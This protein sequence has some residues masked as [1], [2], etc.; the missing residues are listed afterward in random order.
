MNDD[1]HLLHTYAQ[2]RPYALVSLTRDEAEGTVSADTV[3]EVRDLRVALLI[4]LRQ[5][6]HVTRA[7]RREV[8]VERAARRRDQQRTGSA[9]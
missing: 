1:Q 2:H 8:R 6:F 4:A 7:I 5:T 3:R 9:A